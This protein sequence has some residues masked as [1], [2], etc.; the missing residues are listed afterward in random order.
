MVSFS[1]ALW[2]NESIRPPGLPRLGAVE[3]LSK[4]IRR[5][6]RVGLTLAGLIAAPS[7]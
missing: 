2:Y 5:N 1:R 3:S 6:G 4:S 7:R